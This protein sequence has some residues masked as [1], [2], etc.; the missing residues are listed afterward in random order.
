MLA[1]GS[2]IVTLDPVMPQ[3]LAWV[4]LAGVGI[5]A[6]VSHICMT[7]AL[8]FA[9]SATL[10]PLHYSEIVMAVILGLTVFGH[11]PNALTWVGIAVICGA[12]LY[13]IH[14]ERLAASRRAAAILA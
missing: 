6:A 1:Q 7:Y 10:A 12:G 9:P 11:F 2:G 13:V 3:G 5:W 8:K 4:W 14:R